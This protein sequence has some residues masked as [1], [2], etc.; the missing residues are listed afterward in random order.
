VVEDTSAVL[1]NGD[2]PLLKAMVKDLDTYK[3]S[4]ISSP[5][6][7]LPSSKGQMVAMFSKASRL[8]Y[9]VTHFVVIFRRPIVR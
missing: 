9:K 6:Q 7:P 3:E 5:P 2:I 1:V 8:S 4:S